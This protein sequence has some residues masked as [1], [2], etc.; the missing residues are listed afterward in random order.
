VF[1]KKKGWESKYYV[2]PK[3]SLMRIEKLT[4]KNTNDITNAS[5]MP[6]I[7][8]IVFVLLVLYL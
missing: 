2:G 6:I 4:I 7:T 3:P 8:L 5:R 1:G